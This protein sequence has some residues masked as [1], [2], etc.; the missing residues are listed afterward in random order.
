MATAL[1]RKA[2][3][4]KK[5]SYPVDMQSRKLFWNNNNNTIKTNNK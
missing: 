1:E 2:Q 3:T 5:T 4:N